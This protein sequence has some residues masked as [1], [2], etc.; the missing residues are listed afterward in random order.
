MQ[1]KMFLTRLGENS[2][3]IVTGD[4]TQVDLPPGQPVGPGR[5]VGAA[6]RRRHPGIASSCAS[7]PP[8]WCAIR[9]SARIVGDIVLASRRFPREAN[10]Q[11]LTI[12]A[13]LTHLIVHGFLHILGY[14]HAN[15]AE[16]T[17]WNGWKPGFSAISALPTLT[18]DGAEGPKR[19]SDKRMNDGRHPK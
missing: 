11:G 18:P 9:W 17:G 5:G 15:E 13:H 3:M 1:M 16:A 12:E 19:T 6:R 8:T 2:K 14:D 10:R 4:P 7:P